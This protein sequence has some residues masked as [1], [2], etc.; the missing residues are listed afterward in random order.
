MKKGIHTSERV[1]LCELLR[2]ERRNAGL[3][4][5]QIAKLLCV[6]QSFASKYEAG[7][8]RLD[9]FELMVV[10]KAMKSPFLPF[11]RKLE[12]LAQ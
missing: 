4:Q 5:K 3:T 9:I 8:R 10:C 11:I 7:E 12:R 1:R 2:R 6:P